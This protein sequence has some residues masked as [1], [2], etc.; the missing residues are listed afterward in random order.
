MNKV[1]VNK[2]KNLGRDVTAHKSA[3]LCNESLSSNFQKPC[4]M[5][6]IL[7]NAC[8]PSPGGFGDKIATE[9]PLLGL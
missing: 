2:R 1:Y 7:T 9:E 3:L 6:N 4:K 8:N 5:T